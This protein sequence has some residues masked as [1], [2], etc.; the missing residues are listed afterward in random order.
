MKEAFARQGVPAS[1]QRIT[2]WA[3][4]ARNLARNRYRILKSGSARGAFVFREKDTYLLE[5]TLELQIKWFEDFVAWQDAEFW[6]DLK[7]AA[8][9]VGQPGSGAARLGAKLKSTLERVSGKSFAEK[10]VALADFREEVQAFTSEKRELIK[11]RIDA[12]INVQ[13]NRDRN[14]LDQIA[15]LLQ[16]LREEADG[17]MD[18]EVLGEDE[19][20]V[21]IT[22]SGRIAAA[23]AFGTALRAQARAEV[24]KRRLARDSRNA[25]LLEWLG[26]RSLSAEGSMTIGEDIELELFARRFLF[27][28]RRYLEGISIRYRRYRN[29]RQSEQ[30]WYRSDAIGSSFISALEIDLILLAIL[31][32]GRALL[33]DNRVRREIDGPTFSSLRQFQELLRNQ[34]LVDEATDFSPIQLGCMASLGNLDFRSFFAC[35]DFNQRITEWGVRS[36]TEFKWARRRLGFRVMGTTYRHTRQ[37]NEFAKKLAQ[38]SGGALEPSCLIMSIVRA[39]PRP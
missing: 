38:I 35:G 14:L 5:A 22:K 33:A 11:N 25:K 1:D 16:S 27:S 20:E 17:E 23:T 3:D 32:A 37:L 7:R 8:G 9:A 30:Q 24:T 36:E 29:Q 13:V 31:Q 10:F 18:E 6:D 4:Y 15:V 21:A 19:E 28:I 26:A 34:V 39:F 12:A 2:T